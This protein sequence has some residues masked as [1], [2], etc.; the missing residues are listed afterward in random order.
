MRWILVKQEHDLRGCF[1]SQAPELQG[2]GY[3]VWVQRVEDLAKKHFGPRW[4]ED[5]DRVKYMIRAVSVTLSRPVRRLWRSYAKLGPM[6][7]RGISWPRFKRWVRDTRFQLHLEGGGHR[8]G[9]DPEG[10]TKQGQV[11]KG[12]STKPVIPVRQTKARGAHWGP[13]DSL[14][15]QDQLKGKRHR[16]WQERLDRKAARQQVTASNAGLS[17]GGADARE[18]KVDGDDAK[19]FDRNRAISNAQAR[20]LERE[21]RCFHCFELMRVCKQSRNGP[22]CPK[23]KMGTPLAK[24]AFGDAPAWDNGDPGAST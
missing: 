8:D 23:F 7:E 5:R 14:V 18:S 24:G 10:V 19:P 13:W 1:N 15:G 22:G 4:E 12:R 3:D 2:A 6:P 11:A 21:H 17:Y 16:P 20:Y 9:N